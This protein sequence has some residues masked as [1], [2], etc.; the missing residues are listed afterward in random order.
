M[1][2]RDLYMYFTGFV[3]ISV[4]GFFTERF[5]NSCFSNAIFLWDLKRE[6]STYLRVKIS[7][8]DFKKIRKIARKTK[9][10]V[11]I[12]KKRGLPILA[13]RYRKRKIFLIVLAIII[14]F[15]IFITRFIWNID[16]IG[17]NNINADEIKTLLSENGISVGKLKGSF[18]LDKAIN[19]IRMEREDISWIGI[20]IKGT[21]LIVKI[22]EADKSPEV[23]DV[24]EVCNIVADKSG[25]ISKILVK[26]GTARVE[27][28]DEVKARRFISRRSYGRKV[29][30]H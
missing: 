18:N 26:Q 20:D 15:M 29:Y 6:K 16:I 11:K 23:I 17:E 2:F 22:N 25:E 28:G 19:K 1:D 7:S 21:N 30:R 12:E 3:T 8:K 13:N 24:N 27:V 14:A 10:K 9:C 5:I 4:E